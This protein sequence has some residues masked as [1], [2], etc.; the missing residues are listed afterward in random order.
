[1]K[2]ELFKEMMAGFD[3][4]V[5]HRRGQKA[6]VRVSRFSSGVVVLKPKEIR[7]IRLSLGLSQIDFA[8]YLGTSVACVRSWEQ[9][10]RRPQSAALRLLTI[11]KKKPAALLEFVA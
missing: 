1:M 10:I 3:E 4:A 11:A 9:G 5:K 2:A 6:R 8:H 7:K